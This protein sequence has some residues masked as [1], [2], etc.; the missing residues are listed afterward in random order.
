MFSNNIEYR[1]ALQMK[2]DSA[3]NKSVQLDWILWKI[4]VF[5]KKVDNSSSSLWV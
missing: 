2:L 4:Q 5:K 1:I 3:F